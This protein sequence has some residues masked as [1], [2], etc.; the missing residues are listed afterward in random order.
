MTHRARLLIALVSVTGWAFVVPAQG[1]TPAP[2][3]PAPA[4]PATAAA[5]PSRSGVPYATVDG[6]PLL[7]DLYL[8]AGVTRPPLFIWV[9]G[10]AWR[11]GS[12]ANPPTAFVTQQGFALA[13]LDFRQSTDAPFPAMAHD[14]KAAVRFLRA[15]ASSYGYNADRVAIGGDSS[16]AHLALLVGVSGGV[17]SLEGTLGDDRSQSSRVQAI[18]DYY[19]ASN[20]TTILAQSTPFGLGVREPALQLLLG[21]LPDK[22]VDLAKLA[23]PVFHVDASDPPLLIF[24]GDQDP[25]MPINQSQEIQ[26]V[27]ERL[28]L[29]VTFVVVHGSAHGG[30][31][32][33]R[34][35]NQTK[36]LAFL[37]RTIGSAPR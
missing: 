35:A 37:R 2:Q 12:R 36:T 6:K 10:G 8:P 25:Q 22:A 30:N 13:S 18:V 32:F 4:A 17:D 14:I 31:A 34:D 29:D 23:S 1:T 16:G 21:A 24:H 5:G 7:L 28:G 11:S 26:G 3:T 15:H 19:G 20:L 33:Y 27:Y 9:H